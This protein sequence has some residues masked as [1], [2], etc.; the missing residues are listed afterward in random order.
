AADGED[1]PHAGRGRRVHQVLR[2]ALAELEVRVGVD[3][4]RG[5]SGGGWL[6]SPPAGSSPSPARSQATAPGSP[7][8]SSIR[9]AEAG[10]NGCSKT[11]RE[12]TASASVYRVVS[13]SAWSAAAWLRA[14]THGWRSS[15]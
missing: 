6:T 3:H 7:T 4:A 1:P 9:A 8:A 10:M 15:T 2:G 13:S 12:R 11:A 14:S 5:K